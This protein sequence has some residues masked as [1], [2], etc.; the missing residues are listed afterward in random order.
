M[1]QRWLK[2]KFCFASLTAMLILT[3]AC[4]YG[5]TAASDLEPVI[6]AESVRK[7]PA[8]AAKIQIMQEGTKAGIPYFIYVQD[9]HS[10]PS[11]QQNIRKTLNFIFKKVEP[12]KILIALEGA[13]GEIRPEFLDFF[14]DYPSVN[15][16]MRKDLIFKGELTGAEV[17]AHDLYRQNRFNPE[18]FRGVEEA[19][20]YENHLNAYR[21]VVRQSAEIEAFMNAFQG[22]LLKAETKI[23]NPQLSKFL[24]EVMR[25][26]EGQYGEAFKSAGG[27]SSE[28]LPQFG[29]YLKVLADYA[30]DHLAIDLDQN[31]E[32]IR[33]PQI[34]RLRSIEI[35][36]RGLNHDAAFQEWIAYKKNLET[37]LPEDIVE[38]FAQVFKK[39][40]SQT[41]LSLRQALE[42][43]SMES[44]AH[45]RTLTGYEQLKKLFTI[46]ML[47]SE[48]DPSF[49]IA[50]MDRLEFA[51][52]KKMVKSAKESFW[53]Q[54]SRDYRRLGRLFRMELTYEEWSHIKHQAE[55]L[56]PDSMVQRL[57]FLGY[58]K[59][60][61]SDLSGL[62]SYEAATTFYAIAELR[63]KVLFKNT[64]QS[65]QESD[66]DLIIL[67]S[68]G[69]HTGGIQALLKEQGYAFAVIR[70]VI[71]SFD[72]GQLY[73]RAM[74]R[75]NS[76]VFN[77]T[78][79]RLGS[80]QVALTLKEIL[81]VGMPLIAK[82]T[83]KTDYELAEFVRDTVN[84]HPLLKDALEVNVI[85]DAASMD[86]AHLVFTTPGFHLSTLVKRL[87]TGA[88]GAAS[89][90]VPDDRQFSWPVDIRDGLPVIELGKVR[91]E[92]RTGPKVNSGYRKYGASRTPEEA[93]A[94]VGR[95]IELSSLQR[96]G[97][98][99]KNHLAQAG[100]SGGKLI[101][102]EFVEFAGQRNRGFFTGASALKPGRDVVTA[103]TLEGFKTEAAKDD[104]LT[105]AVRGLEK[106]ARV[107]PTD[108]EVKNRETGWELFRQGKV[109]V[110]SLAGGM[111]VRGA[112]YA[113]HLIYIPGYGK[114]PLLAVQLLNTYFLAQK[115]GLKKIPFTIAES[116]YTARNVS[117]V[118]HWMAARGLIKVEDVH[119][120]D[121]SVINRIDGA[122]NFFAEDHR[123]GYA[124]AS[125]FDGLLY[126]I[127]SGQYARAKQAGVLYAK[128]SNMNIPT[129]TLDLGIIGY[130]HQKRQEEQDGTLKSGVLIEQ[131]LNKNEKGG[132]RATAHYTMPDGENR[133]VQQ[134]I[135]SFIVEGT[136]DFDK[137]VSH[138]E[139][140]PVFNANSIVVS[141]DWIEKFFGLNDLEQPPTFENVQNT[142][143]RDQLVAQIG[144]KISKL[145]DED[146]GHKIQLYYELKKIKNPETGHAEFVL[147]TS[148]L[149]GQTATVD[150]HSIF[151]TVP[152]Q[153]EK[154]SR[155]DEAKKQKNISANSAVWSR[156]LVPQL[157][158]PKKRDKPLRAADQLMV[159]MDDFYLAAEAVNEEA[160]RGDHAGF[161]LQAAAY[162]SEAFNF[163]NFILR[164][165]DVRDAVQVGEYRSYLKDISEAADLTHKMARMQTFMGGKR[166]EVREASAILSTSAFAAQ[167]QRSFERN[168]RNPAV[169][170]VALD[171]G[172]IFGNTETGRS[173]LLAS[174]I[175]P[176]IPAL[177]ALEE[178]ALGSD[179]I[180]IF[181]PV[182]DAIRL[183]RGRYLLREN[184]DQL[185]SIDAEM[186]L[187][188]RYIATHR[189]FTWALD[190]DG[191]SPEEIRAFK[192]RLIENAG[193]WGMSVHENQ[194]Q[195]APSERT[196][197]DLSLLDR[198][199]K[200]QIF[201]Y[202]S[203]KEQN[204]ELTRADTKASFHRVHQSSALDR[205][206]A[207]EALRYAIR[208][209]LQ[210]AIGPLRELAAAVFKTT[211]DVLEA[212]F[213]A[214]RNLAS[215]A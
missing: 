40:P 65:A 184:I 166:S 47:Q 71:N 191:V 160:H 81:D 167:A 141:L 20:L 136:P 175:P 28:V 62:Q 67:I 190:V 114:V 192:L 215:S 193:L 126:Y 124:V 91:S 125:H 122:G 30:R 206:L 161:K 163:Y 147:Q 36:E 133:E 182:A 180:D 165:L 110:V 119:R 113:N 173:E 203:N 116:D 86:S 55:Q 177:T 148:R 134:M 109:E 50:E 140:F 90:F 194:L 100:R 188:V 44:K 63:D 137:M 48:L 45:Y 144:K 201:G 156:Y 178:G 57:Q 84:R 95:A 96:V 132:F 162:E 38:T 204:L 33:F 35:L 94:S 103:S 2:N 17:F 1:R 151:Y 135:E 115:A 25:Q 41:R 3:M 213:A 51:V 187:W 169:T 198:L 200:D 21:Q 34:F 210:R 98:D 69:F 186:R 142:L 73:H 179:F 82:I 189:D 152:R 157:P 70:P 143:Y 102:Q 199:A 121:V 85:K 158:A 6:S 37:L 195:F 205:L 49:L 79:I 92:V 87:L 214:Y 83:G 68:G 212:G 23:L 130:L 154:A 146:P 112:I 118:L 5:L 60:I 74:N 128:F 159:M 12:A 19:D 149:L 18:L 75:G 29:F 101:S 202:L 58:G 16:A 10:N 172:G 176:V 77:Q 54:L 117:E 97:E 78:G 26:R 76:N 14:S 183:Q 104:S 105:A 106:L 88:R 139:D 107:I 120:F 185:P 15:E 56:S 181:F 24:K 209:D 64:I 31:I 211:Y 46:K 93:R 32:Q 170:S 59:S 8:D 9:A 7:I 153:T 52:A 89:Q 155:Y 168:D 27:D 80:E 207:A 43:L 164:S 39:K 174:S 99:I 111:S 108:Q 66:A 61:F 208:D 196:G 13:T 197:F 145:G 22:E 72:Q 127:Y 123:E 129:A 42:K 138:K 53:L 11:A 171:F 131:T 150:P 4:P